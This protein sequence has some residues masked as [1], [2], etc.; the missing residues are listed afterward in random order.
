MKNIDKRYCSENFTEMKLIKMPSFVE[1]L[2]WKGF[3]RKHDN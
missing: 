2:G 1:H 3:V